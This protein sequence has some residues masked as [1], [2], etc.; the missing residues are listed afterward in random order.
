[1][2]KDP[3]PVTPEGVEC[4]DSIV[5]GTGG[6]RE[7]SADLYLPSEPA[8]S[9]LPAVVYVHGG[10]LAGRQQSAVLASRHRDGAARLRGALHRVQARRQGASIPARWR[11]PTAP[12]GS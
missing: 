2:S 8:A 3:K 1:M 11:T 4:R 5:F 6:G 9:A 12:C 7:L 10:A